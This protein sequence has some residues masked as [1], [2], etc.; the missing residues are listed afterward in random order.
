MVV[1]DRLSRLTRGLN[2]AMMESYTLCVVYVP[3][4]RTDGDFLGIFFCSGASS[5][6]VQLTNMSSGFRGPPV[7]LSCF[8][9]VFSFGDGDGVLIQYPDSP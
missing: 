6:L 7:S 9:F 2:V 1:G 4:M 8:A 5:R 3:G